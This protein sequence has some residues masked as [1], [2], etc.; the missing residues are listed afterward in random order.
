M[1]NQHRLALALITLAAVSLTASDADWNQ[2]RGPNRNGVLPA[3]PKLADLW[4]ADGPKLLWESEPIP[5]NDLGGHGSAVIVGDKVY[6]SVVWHED[7]PS[8]SRTIDQIVT[9]KLGMRGVG[10]LGDKLVKELDEIVLNLSP[11]LR[12]NK[13]TETAEKWVAENLDKKQKMNLGDY[14]ISRFKKGRKNIPF[15]DYAKVEKVVGRTF[16][17]DDAF[18]EWV[19]KQGFSDFVKDQVIKA[20][21]PTIRVAKDTIVCLSLKTGKILWRAAAPGE[22]KGRNCSSTPAVVDGFVYGI[23]STHLYCVNA[24]TGEAVWST[25]VNR[26]GVGSSP[27]VI[28]GVVVVHANNITAYDTRTGKVKWEHPKLRVTNSSPV[29]WR[30]NGRTFVISNTRDALVATN[31]EDGAIQWTI[32]AGGD[33]TPA[34][35]GDYLAVQARS[36]KLGFLGFKLDVKEPRQL[37][38]I[39]FLARR[40]QSSPII[41]GDRVYLI[42]NSTARCVELKTGREIWQ[43]SVRSAITSPVMADGKFYVITDRGNNLTMFKPGA[44]ELTELGKHRIK[45]LY[46]PSPSV[47]NGRIILRQEDKLV[48]YDISEGQNLAN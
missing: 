4:S 36:E 11:R 42:D 23:G 27:L 30:K 13:L 21:P 38:S 37:W 7:V 6:M 32:T 2:W 20:V 24:E 15:A 48:A 22:P 34:I 40:T 12:G 5:G 28:D 1:K 45:A 43:Q 26:K 18:R 25:P 19:D 29:A 3:G 35:Q 10:I 8:D 41:D 47:A 44:K 31:P 39:P 33:C 16:P 14:V 46:C 9:R 17:N